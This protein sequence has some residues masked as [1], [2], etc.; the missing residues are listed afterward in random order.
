MNT[1]TSF[2]S[3]FRAPLAG[4]ALASAAVLGACGAPAAQE[5]LSSQGIPTARLQP[6]T[7]TAKH[8]EVG[9]KTTY[10]VLIP[11]RQGRGQVGII[12][13]FEGWDSLRSFDKDDFKVSKFVRKDNGSAGKWK[14]VDTDDATM[15][16]DG[17]GRISVTIPFEEYEQDV[18]AYRVKVN[19]VRNPS[20]GPLFN[21]RVNVWLNL[22]EYTN[23]VG[24]A[25]WLQG[26]YQ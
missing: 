4:L 23:Y 25:T 3:W 13:V 24:Q 16:M 19:D 18:D 14:G 22:G 15:F 10:K 1:V 20:H 11:N 21:G 8:Q 5:E 12:M 2:R 9:K 17:Y 7:I 6:L 26:A